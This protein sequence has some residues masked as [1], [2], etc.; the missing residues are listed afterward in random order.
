M[1]Q[2]RP[3]VLAD[4]TSLAASVV[5]PNRHGNSFGSMRWQFR[6]PTTSTP[7]GKFELEVSEDPRVETDIARGLYGTGSETARWVAIALSADVHV[8]KTAGSSDTTI[9]AADVTIAGAQLSEF[10]V[11]CQRPFSNMR[12]RYTRTS[13]S[14]TVTVWFGAGS[15]GSD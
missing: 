12:W 5:L 2:A 14:G 4:A 3:Q 15:N 8:H 7:A 9:N 11:E 6:I 1:S 13:G 10:V